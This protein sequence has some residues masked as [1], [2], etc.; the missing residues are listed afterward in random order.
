MT[1]RRLKSRVE[2]CGICAKETK[3]LAEF[4]ALLLCARCF[5]G[6][7]TAFAEGQTFK[8]RVVIA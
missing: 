8:L 6:A 4:N 2:K 5:D 7:I 1:P 3:Y